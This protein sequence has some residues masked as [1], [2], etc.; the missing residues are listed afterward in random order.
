MN[1][2]VHGWFC[3]PQVS[4]SQDEIGACQVNCCAHVQTLVTR[5][6][7]ECW[8][9]YGVECL[10]PPS[11]GALM[12]ASRMGLKT[13]PSLQTAVTQLMDA[14]SSIHNH[15]KSVHANYVPWPGSIQRS[16]PNDVACGLGHKSTL[17]RIHEQQYTWLHGNEEH[18]KWSWPTDKKPSW[19][20]LEAMCEFDV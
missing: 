18:C 11:D 8:G 3:G 14:R 16:F 4:L 1:M 5:A 15:F 19:D 7:C 20:S 13:P 12:S 6:C 17:L 10:T 2:D 9:G